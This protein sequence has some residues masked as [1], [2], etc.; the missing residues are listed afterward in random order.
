MLIE[1][2]QTRR[3]IPFSHMFAMKEYPRDVLPL[4]AQGHSL[5]K[6]LI[7]QR[8]KHEF[9]QFLADGLKDDDWLR[10]LDQAYGYPNLLTLQNSW[11]DWIRQGRPQLQ[12]ASDAVLVASHNRPISRGPIAQGPV[13]RG[14]DPGSVNNS[15]TSGLAGPVRSD[16]AAP[17]NWNSVAA[18]GASPKTPGGPTAEQ[19]W[20]A[21]KAKPVRTPPESVYDAS[22][23]TGTLRR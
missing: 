11:M 15:G 3:G 21:E 16:S 23:Q 9:L 8:G 20:P 10:A 18:A 19:L 4:Y 5:S 12:L 7:D 6:F 1:F 2:L 17:G 14:Q 13:V 22:R